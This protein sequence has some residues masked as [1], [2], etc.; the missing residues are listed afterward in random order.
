MQIKNLFV[1]IHVE[2]RV[3][4]VPKTS[5]GLM[6]IMFV[7][8]VFFVRSLTLMNRLYKAVLLLWIIFVIYDLFCYTF[9][10]FS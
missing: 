6:W 8:Y 7:I 4:L 9:H 3:R 5:L 10:W 1:L 2:I